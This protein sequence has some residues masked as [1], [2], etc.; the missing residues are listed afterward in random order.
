MNCTFSDEDLR[1]NEFCEAATG[2][3]V[4]AAEFYVTVD[5]KFIAPLPFPGIPFVGCSTALSLK[6]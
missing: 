2:N 3:A 6:R 1:R 5:V 4:H